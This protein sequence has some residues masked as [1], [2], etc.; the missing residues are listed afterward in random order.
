MGRKVLL[1][2][3][4][5]TPGSQVRGLTL[6]ELASQVQSLMKTAFNLRQDDVC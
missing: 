4:I 5:H 3:R 6:I 2:K 1:C